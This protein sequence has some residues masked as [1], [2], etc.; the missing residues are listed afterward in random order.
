LRSEPGSG[1]DVAILSVGVYFDAPA[2]IDPLSLKLGPR[3]ANIWGD[4]GRARDVDGDG[5]D[6]LVVKF[7]TDQTG[8]ACGDTGANLSGYTVNTRFIFG[9]NAVN[10]FNC[11]RA[12]KRY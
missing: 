11:P 2:Q 6:D 1:F 7:L 4:G 8:I 5:D 9:S 12:R 3:G 10:T